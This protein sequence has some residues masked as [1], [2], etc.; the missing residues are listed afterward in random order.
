MRGEVV[1]SD[2]GLVLDGGA[3]LS[4]RAPRHREDDDG[5]TARGYGPA[6]SNL[7]PDKGLFSEIGSPGRDFQGNP[8]SRHASLKFYHLR[9]LNHRLRTVRTHQRNLSVALAEIQRLSSVLGLSREVKESATFIYRKALEHKA[10]RGKKIV[11]L[12]AAS[13]YA[14]CRQCRVPRTMK[15]II[16]HSKASK[17]EVGRAFTLLARELHLGLR[18][19]E[20]RDYLVRFTQDLNLSRDVRQRVLELLAQVEKVYSTSGVLPN[21]VLATIIYIACNSLG[22]PRS[23]DRIAAVAN[24]TPVTIRN[25]YKEFLD[26]LGL[27][28]P[29]PNVP[30]SARA[31]TISAGSQ[32]GANA[33]GT[34]H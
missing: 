25:H 13:V 34:A 27:P 33:L 10:T 3:F 12:V 7:L 32:L 20:P 6:I 11:S 31:V 5:R 30:A 26:L 29:T 22:E 23:Q 16:V 21:G 14:A 15:E 24:V 4:D 17:I 8:L 2:C 18:P 9:K 19:I 1:C 28:R